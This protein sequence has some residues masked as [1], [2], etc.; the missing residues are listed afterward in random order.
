MLQRPVVGIVC[1]ILKIYT[2]H[3]SVLLSDFLSCSIRSMQIDVVA[4]TFLT[5]GRAKAVNKSLRVRG[6]SVN[7]R[8]RMMAIVTNGWKRET[9]TAF[10]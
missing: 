1:F 5:R 8:R 6:R 2:M 3:Y 9:Q 10:L 7:D 4:V